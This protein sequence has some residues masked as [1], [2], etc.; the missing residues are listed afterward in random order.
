MKIVITGGAGYIGSHTVR[1]VIA[2]GHQ[3]V[4]LDNLEAGHIQAIGDIPLE[5]VDLRNRSQVVEV[6]CKHRPQ[7]VIHFAAYCQVGESVLHPGKYYD[8]NLTASLNLLQAMVETE[9]KSIV[10]SSTAA[11][12]GDPGIEIID[13][14]T[15]QM[16]INP[17]GRSKLF[18]EQ[19]LQDYTQAHG[20][21]FIPLRYFNASGAH[22]QG[23]MGEDHT[24]ETHLIPLVLYAAM[25]KRKNITIFGT[26]FPTP[27]GTCIR[28]FIH[29][30]DLA[31]A[32]VLALEK[33]SSRGK[34]LI[35]ARGKDFPY[36]R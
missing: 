19:L 28:D 27:D 26:D 3:A 13:E 16:P 36:E 17:Y 10:F 20:I 21:N 12:Y 14:K 31:R 15:P 11:T 1:E 8:N 29:V 9:V 22:P 5:K 7:A 25:G 2:Q 4:V 33:N 24:P 18:L 30:C 23:D 34:R 32:H 6:F 35:W